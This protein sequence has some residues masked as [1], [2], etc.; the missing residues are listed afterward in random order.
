LAEKY[1]KK[2]ITTIDGLK[3]DFSEGWVHL[4]KSNTEPII[5]IYAESEGE[6]KANEFAINMINE[7]KELI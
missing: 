1:K 4:R 6:E 7:I 2:K 5:R 3:I